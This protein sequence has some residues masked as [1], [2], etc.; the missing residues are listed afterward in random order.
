MVGGVAS[1]G[2]EAEA[3]GSMKR[4]SSFT[5]NSNDNNDEPASSSSSAMRALSIRESVDEI[6]SSRSNSNISSGGGGNSGGSGSGGD[7]YLADLSP[8][9]R[10]I[11]ERGGGGVSEGARFIPATITL[12]HGLLPL[13]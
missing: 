6:R 9:F 11:L 13:R 10:A 2:V 4:F 8:G 3:L 1:G 12:K 5:D 7:W